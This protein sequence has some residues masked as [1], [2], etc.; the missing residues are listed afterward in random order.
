MCGMI[1]AQASLKRFNAG[2]Y[3]GSCLVLYV[4][5]DTVNQQV[6]E[7]L[8]S[9]H[10]EYRVLLACDQQEVEDIL[11]EEPCLPDVVL[12]DHQLLNCTGVEVCCCE[13]GYLLQI[14][15]IQKC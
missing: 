14:S 12:M 13:F 3:P 6:L 4:D 15:S 1:K 10:P 9:S 11:K 8:L 5:D 7:M 2:R